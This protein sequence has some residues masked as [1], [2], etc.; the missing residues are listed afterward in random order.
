MLIALIVGL[1]VGLIAKFL[2]PGR[3]SG[4][5]FVTALLGI[6]GSLLAHWIG[7]AAGW[8]GPNQTAGFFASVLGAMILVLAFRMI[9]SRR[10]IPH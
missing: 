3:D 10:R 9:M 2:V 1:F 7:V 4:G 5:L 8:Y 6:G